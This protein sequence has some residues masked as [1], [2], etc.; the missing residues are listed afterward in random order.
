MELSPYNAPAGDQQTDWCL[1]KQVRPT[2]P[3]Q[4]GT[5]KTGAYAPFPIGIIRGNALT[6]RPPSAAHPRPVAQYRDAG[7]SP[8]FL[9]WISV[10]SIEFERQIRDF[11]G[12][13][14]ATIGNFQQ[15]LIYTQF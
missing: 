10:A 6:A 12:K 2:I 11:K 3:K 14:S 4:Y 5:K 13:K 7:T 15:K 9:S 8:G 1:F